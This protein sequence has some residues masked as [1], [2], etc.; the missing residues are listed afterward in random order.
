MIWPQNSKQMTTTIYIRQIIYMTRWLTGKWIT[1]A[2]RWEQKTSR[3]SIHLQYME[4]IQLL[5]RVIELTGMQLHS[6]DEWVKDERPTR[7]IIQVILGM[8]SSYPLMVKAHDNYIEI[9]SWIFSTISTQSK[10]SYYG[11]HHTHRRVKYFWWHVDLNLQN[12]YH[13]LPTKCFQ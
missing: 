10:Y 12:I 2:W 3:H 8:D 13:V 4:K 6:Y 5:F 11:L 9:M 7:H 1:K